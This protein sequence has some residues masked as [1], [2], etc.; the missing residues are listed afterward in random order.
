MYRIL[1]PAG[2]CLLLSAASSLALSLD[3]SNKTS[4]TSAAKT[5]ADSI[6]STYNGTEPGQIPGLFTGPYYWWESGL[7]WDGLVNYWALTGD[8][9]YNDIVNQALSWQVGSGNNY[10]PVNQTKAEGNDDQSTWA[11]AAMTAAEQGFPNPSVEGSSNLTW[12]QLAENV[13]NEQAARWDQQTCGG[14]VR[15]QIFTFN[16]GYSYKNSLTNGNF[17]QLAARLALYTG[18]STYSDWAQRV[19][20]WS[21]QSGLISN[22]TGAVYDGFDTTTN[23]S[24]A[25]H[26]QWTSSTGTYL[27][28]ASYLQNYVSA[29]LHHL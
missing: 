11:L 13:F 7:V 4:V 25:N 6:M 3:I 18:N 2:T 26:I 28:G 27:S 5:I 10:M 16:A 17:Y 29:I 24:Q 14:G 19:L 8:D 22:E 23:C 21:T 1:G 12:A 20:T 9:S 15:W